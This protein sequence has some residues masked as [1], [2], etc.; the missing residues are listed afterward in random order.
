MHTYGASQNDDDDD[1]GSAY[2]E[3]LWV[4][5]HPLKVSQKQ[6]LGVVGENV[7]SPNQYHQSTAAGMQ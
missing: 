7:P 1:N 6:P 4:I 5:L 2:L 3:L